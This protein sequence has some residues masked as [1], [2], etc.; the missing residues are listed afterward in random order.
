MGGGRM[1]SGCHTPAPAD[2][3]P[4]ARKYA[5]AHV[6]PTSAARSDRPVDP[7]ND[8]RPPP[9]VIVGLPRSGTTWTLRVLGTSPG[10]IK[11]L[12]PDHEE[13]FAAAIH[14]KRKLGRYPSLEPGQ[15]A[16]AYRSLW[17]WILAGGQDTWRSIQARRLLG[18]RYETRIFDGRMDLTTV[19]AS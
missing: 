5:A 2:N 17:E 19:V 10:A 18:P 13:K 11:T 1:H 6:P 9:I 15:R 16:A 12:E 3:R 14:A 8:H 7:L 4:D